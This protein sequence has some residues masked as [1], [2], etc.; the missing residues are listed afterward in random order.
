VD[1]GAELDLTLGAWSRGS[2]S[3]EHDVRWEL[4]LFAPLLS[5][6]RE[7]AAIQRLHDSHL[8]TQGATLLTR[9][10]ASE[11]AFRREAPRHRYLH[12]AT[13]GFTAPATADQS[14]RNAVPEPRS[15]S[16][17]EALLD[18]T[19]LHPG[20]LAGVAL[21]GANLP[22]RAGEGET[23]EGKT[24]QDDGL[25]TAEEV[26]T[27][28]LTGVELTVLSACDTGLGRIAG[29]EGLLGLQRAFQVAG[30]RTVVASFWQV[31]DRATR[32]LMQR[33]YEN[34]W[35]RDMSRLAALREAQIWMLDASANETDLRLS[36]EAYHDGRLAPRYW[37]AF[38]LS[39]EWR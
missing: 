28:D 8:P 36:D 6:G 31:H 35:S 7:I 32:A 10:D 11:A 30:A 5:T 23:D 37:A 9:L 15:A 24:A 12:L 29:G 19:E 20:L 3:R 14:R 4:P 38:V 26:T 1:Y 22:S 2:P 18:A 21:A 17:Q 33:F 25:L 27:L 34:L 16:G 39:G 13:H